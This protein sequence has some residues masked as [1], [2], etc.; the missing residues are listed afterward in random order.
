[1]DA[2]DEGAKKRFE[3]RTAESWFAERPAESW[4][5]NQTA[6]SWFQ[7]MIRGDKQQRDTEWNTTENEITIPALMILQA[8]ILWQT[9]LY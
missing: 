4:A 8:I 3:K 9:G 2:D 5:E 6:E 1:M 7:T